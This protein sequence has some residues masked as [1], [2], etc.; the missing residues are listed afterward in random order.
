MAVSVL[1]AV[2]CS[3]IFDCG[4]FWSYSLAFLFNIFNCGLVPG[5]STWLGQPWPNWGFDFVLIVCEFR[6]LY[7][8]HQR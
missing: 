5:S 1:C 2:D 7:L 8:F 6:A 4:I 3:E